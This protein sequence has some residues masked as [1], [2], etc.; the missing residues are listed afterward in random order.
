VVRIGTSETSAPSFDEALS[1]RLP[2]A[3]EAAAT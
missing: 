2:R 3:T 1:L